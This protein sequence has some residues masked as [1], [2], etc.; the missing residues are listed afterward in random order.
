MI[1]VTSLANKEFII[2][3]EHIEKIDAVPES[4]ITL[5]NGNKYIVIEGFD[6]IIDRVVQYKRK[7]H[8]EAFQEE[9][10]E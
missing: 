1:K 5:V 4:L 8:L 6:E 2:N 3:A 10:N 7:I 9:K